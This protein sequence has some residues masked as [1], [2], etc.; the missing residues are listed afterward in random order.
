MTMDL[1][2][3]RSPLPHRMLGWTMGLGLGLLL[4][5]TAV[6]ERSHPLERWL[7]EGEALWLEVEGEA[8]PAVLRGAARETARGGVLLLAG[9]G[10]HADAPGVIG[11]LRRDLADRGWK[12]LALERSPDGASGARIEAGLTWLLDHLEA[13]E[14]RLVVLGHER[15]AAD[16]LN[17]LGETPTIEPYALVLVNVALPHGDAEAEVLGRLEGLDLPVLDIFHRG[18]PSA[19]VATAEARLRSARRAGN[20]HYRQDALVDPAPRQEDDATL[21]RRIGGWLLAPEG[22]PKS[23][24]PASSRKGEQ[25]REVRE[26][27][28]RE[29]NDDLQRYFTPPPG[30][31]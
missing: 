1:T 30:S 26:P 16:L 22:R 27:A 23:E 17:W 9:R 4:S 28:R 15:G 21:L 20:E 18:A 11:P 7:S 5:G 25:H 24:R 19:V 8:V 31:R 6:A 13:E 2:T 12:T 14:P 10:E 29:D 3:S